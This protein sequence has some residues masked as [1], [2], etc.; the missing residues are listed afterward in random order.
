MNKQWMALLLSAGMAVTAPVPGAEPPTEQMQTIYPDKNSAEPESMENENDDTKE[1][2]SDENA[3]SSEGSSNDYQPEDATSETEDTN[4][5]EEIQENEKANTQDQEI[6]NQKNM[7]QETA[8]T[9]EFLEDRTASSDMETMISFILKADAQEEVDLS[10]EIITDFLS[11]SDTYDQLSE[12]EKASVSP[13][14]TTALENV[15]TRIATKISTDN[16]VTAA[17]NPWYV[18]LHV[19]KNTNQD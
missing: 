7:D 3:E 6:T 18:Q 4:T 2:P 11:A 16:G 8:E 5:S 15:R 19:Q 13:E 9:Q 1:L 14:V 12:E 10:S 17:G